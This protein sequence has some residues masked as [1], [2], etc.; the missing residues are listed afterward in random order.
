MI[1][2]E[3][4]KQAYLDT[5]RETVTKSRDELQVKFYLDLIYDVSLSQ[6]EIVKK[7]EAYQIPTGGF[8]CVLIK[9]RIID[10]TSQPKEDF[11]HLVSTFLR[12][13]FADVKPVIFPLQSRYL[14][15]VLYDNGKLEHTPFIPS[16]NQLFIFAGSYPAYKLDAAV[17]CLHASI[18]ELNTAYLE[19]CYCFKHNVR[20]EKKIHFYSEENILPTDAASFN[21]NLPVK[22]ALQYIEN[23]Y[24]IQIG[25]PDI[26]NEVGLNASYLSRLFKKEVGEPITEYLTRYRIEKAKELLKDNTM[27]L[28]EIAEM[29]GFNDVSYFSNTFKK[30]AGMSPTEYRTLSEIL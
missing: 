5:I 14:C 20:A 19:C 18:T 10:G 27:R 24:G 3:Q 12:N 11:I 6:D 4:K 25:L 7:M 21:Q 29:V 13:I 8:Y 30:V 28:R 22:K 15:V 26:A 9:I 2:E 23:N 1:Q 16:L 17:S